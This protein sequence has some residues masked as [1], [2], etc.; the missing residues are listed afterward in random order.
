MCYE[1]ELLNY[2]SV[3]RI[4]NS[5]AVGSRE[6]DRSPPSQ[7]LI[8]FARRGTKL[9]KLTD[10]SQLRVLLSGGRTDWNTKV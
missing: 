10:S 6:I 1:I 9:A 7:A 8:N 3:A 5:K 4:R 2:Y